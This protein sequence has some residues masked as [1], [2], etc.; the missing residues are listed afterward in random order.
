MFSK[1]KLLQL[2]NGKYLFAARAGFSDL[3]VWRYPVI[4]RHGSHYLHWLSGLNTQDERQVGDDTM[5]EAL[6]TYLK[7]LRKTNRAKEIT[8]VAKWLTLKTAK[9]DIENE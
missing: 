6:Q 7:V 1:Y 5:K 2:P 8:E 3:F 9:E 4:Y